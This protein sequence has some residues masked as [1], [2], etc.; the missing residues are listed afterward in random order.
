MLDKIIGVV[1]SFIVS[2]SLGYCVSTIKNY[3]NKAKTKKENDSLQNEAL[4]TLLRSNLTNVYFVYSEL[5]K[6]PDYTYQNFLSA[7]KVYEKLGGDGFVHNIA[8]KMKNW[9]ITK[10]DI[11]K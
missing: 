11:L 8:D 7:L 9:D 6:I 1:I 3:K 4:L 2:G 10:T 5:K